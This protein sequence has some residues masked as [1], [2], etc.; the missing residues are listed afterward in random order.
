MPTLTAFPRM[1]NQKMPFAA[2]MAGCGRVRAV[3]PGHHTNPNNTWAFA[4]YRL[5]LWCSGHETVAAIEKAVRELGRDRTLR[6]AF[7]T[8]A[9]LG[10]RSKSLAWVRARYVAPPMGKDEQLQARLAGIAKK[11]Q[12]AETRARALLAKHTKA[13]QR[14]QRLVRKWK[15]KV[16][17]YDSKNR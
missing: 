12:R 16:A 15:A 3:E 4:L 8:V 5:Y 17:Y 6:E 7:T 2:F 10:D 9:A 1:R 14:E 13:L 11:A